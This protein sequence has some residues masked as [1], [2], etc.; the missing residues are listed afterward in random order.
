MASMIA[1]DKSKNGGSGWDTRHNTALGYGLGWSPM[2]I[3][4]THETTTVQMLSA[5]AG[6]ARAHRER[7]ES[8]I[9]E[10]YV[11]GPHWAEVGLGVRGLLNG[12]TGRLD[13]GTLDAFILDTLSENG[14][15]I[16]NL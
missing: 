13:C 5:W 15:D 7:F 12:E 10:D 8:L 11:L 6:Y 4:T 16:N 3:L 2:A 9:G 14:I 1:K